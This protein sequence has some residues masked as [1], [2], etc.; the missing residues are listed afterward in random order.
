MNLLRTAILD[1]EFLNR[2]FDITEEKVAVTHG[3][4]YLIFTHQRIKIKFVIDLDL[5]TGTLVKINDERIRYQHC[6]T[7]QS[8]DE[9]MLLLKSILEQVGL[10]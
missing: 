1:D 5:D 7:F 3:L 8:V 10:I 6:H 4:V 9:L 2:V